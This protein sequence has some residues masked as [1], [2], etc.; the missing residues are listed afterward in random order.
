MKESDM[1]ITSSTSTDASPDAPMGGLLASVS[2]TVVRGVDA[3]LQGTDIPLSADHWYAL[4]LIVRRDG[5]AMNDIARTL[6]TPPP[7]VTKIVDHLVGNALAFRLADD[8]DRRRLFV[9]ASKRGLE[10]HQNTRAAVI[11]AETALIRGLTEEV[12]SGIRSMCNE[13]PTG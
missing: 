13:W 7:T 4:D 8:T 6:S 9:H 10:F 2:R 3:A 1:T 12:L 5:V 11:A